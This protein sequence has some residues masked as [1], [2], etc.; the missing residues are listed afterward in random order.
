MYQPPHEG[1]EPGLLDSCLACL[2]ALARCL[3]CLGSELGSSSGDGGQRLLSTQAESHMGMGIEAGGSP[4]GSS[5]PEGGSPTAVAAAAAGGKQQ[6]K[7]GSKVSLQEEEEDVC[8]TCLDPY[9]EDNP[10]VLTRCGHHFHLPCLYEWLE[11]S[12]TCPVCGAAMQFDEIV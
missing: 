9:S 3:C 8:P 1:R 6:R 4:N 5:S 10:M 11:R 12:E 7:G 2:T